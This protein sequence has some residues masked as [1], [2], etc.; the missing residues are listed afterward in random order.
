MP[1]QASMP[2]NISKIEFKNVVIMDC[3]ED[4]NINLESSSDFSDSDASPC[5][6]KAYR[7]SIFTEFHQ[8]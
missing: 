5:T 1:Q 2:L 6:P 7:N 4:G 8:F 3:D